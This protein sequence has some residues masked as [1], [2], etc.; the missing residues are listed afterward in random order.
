MDN[1]VY[2]ALSGQLGVMRKMDATANNLANVDTVGYH[3]EKMMFTDYLVDDGNRHKMAF[4]QDISSYRVEQNGA[5]KVTGGK[6]DVAIDGPGFFSI[7]TPA[8]VRYTRAGN[9]K[10]NNDG[11]LV[12]TDNY[13]VL[14][15]G[16]AEIA[17][18]PEVR[19]VTVGENGA[20]RSD[21]GA[22][23][24]Q[25]GVAEFADPQEL[26]RVSSQFY[27]TE[28]QPLAAAESRVLHGALESS[29]V[30]PVQEL[31]ETTKLSRATSSS[32]KFIEVIYDLQRKT[33]NAYAR[34]SPK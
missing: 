1:S 7:E 4:S 14:D 26:V 34:Q 29:N 15:D 8:G 20:I 31:V 5:I 2:I 24:G 6:F 9:F 16:G 11:I 25:I 28:Q 10:L 32:A 18:P 30:S 21:A 12:T 17:I 27:K 22:E 33:S 3:A 23:L 19:E 13:P